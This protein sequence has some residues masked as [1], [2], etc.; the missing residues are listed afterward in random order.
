MHTTYAHI[1]VDEE[2]GRLSLQYWFFWYFN[3]WN[4]TH[5]ADWENVQL[6]WDDIGGLEQALAW[7]RG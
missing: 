4:N 3:D 5:E 7:R 6:F 2:E 1:V